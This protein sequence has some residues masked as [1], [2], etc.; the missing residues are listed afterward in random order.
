MQKPNKI[1]D[2][3]EQNK[4]KSINNETIK[5]SNQTSKSTDGN[6]L[7]FVTK[8]NGATLPTINIR[9]K[10]SQNAFQKNSI[11]NEIHQFIDL[12]DLIRHQRSQIYVIHQNKSRILHCSRTKKLLK[13]AAI[14]K[15]SACQL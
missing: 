13:Q 12:Y 15:C 5:V 9:A 14:K 7:N 1:D 4:H 8:K 6:K 11:L 2:L 10:T 3:P